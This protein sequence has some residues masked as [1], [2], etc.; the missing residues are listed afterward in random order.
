MG[1][2][3]VRSNYKRTFVSSHPIKLTTFL[4]FPAKCAN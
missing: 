3:D 4:G 2:L 1:T